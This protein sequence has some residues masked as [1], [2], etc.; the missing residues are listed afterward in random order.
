[1]ARRCETR[2]EFAVSLEESIKLRRLRL[3][4]HR[5]SRVAL[6]RGRILNI[7]ERIA[8]RK[9]VVE[10]YF[11]PV[12]SPSRPG[13]LGLSDASRIYYPLT[14]PMCLHSPLSTPRRT[15]SRK[16]LNTTS[17]VDGRLD[18]WGS[19]RGD[20]FPQ[21]PAPHLYIHPVTRRTFAKYTEDRYRLGLSAEPS[22]AIEVSG[23]LPIV[24]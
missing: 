11:F 6:S 24:Q 7:T 18:T 12:P 13:L 9:R 1:M 15:L 16:I 21:P 22:S 20:P 23:S 4:P 8:N 2:R 14:T 3:C 5:A 17:Q 19:E 10:L